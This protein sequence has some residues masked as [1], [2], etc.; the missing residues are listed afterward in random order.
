MASLQNA[1]A[2]PE[3]Y[4]NIEPNP[5]QISLSDLANAGLRVVNGRYLDSDGN[6]LTETEA[7]DLAMSARGVAKNKLSLRKL[8]IPVLLLGVG[9]FLMTK[10]KTRIAG[11]VVGGLGAV[12]GVMTFIK[13]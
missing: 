3:L 10:K 8:I 7:Q 4:A 6:E 5:N 11:Y 12:Y 13:K 1:E 9:G 2:N